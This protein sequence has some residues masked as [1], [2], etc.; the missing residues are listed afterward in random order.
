MGVPDFVGHLT[1]MDVMS[2]VSEVPASSA[3]A[4]AE[5]WAEWVQQPEALVV[6]EA[7]VSPLVVQLVWF[8]FQG[9]VFPQTDGHGFVVH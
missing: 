4:V 1:E 5:W 7:L 2:Q 8:E 3:Q 6:Q 9:L